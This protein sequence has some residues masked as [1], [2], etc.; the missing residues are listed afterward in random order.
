[1]QMS[2]G[3]DDQD[4]VHGGFLPPQAPP[5]VA[6]PGSS[7]GYYGGPLTTGMPAP[8]PPQQGFATPPVAPTQA[9]PA[10]GTPPPAWQPWMALAALAIAFIG[11]GVLGALLFVVAAGGEVDVE[12]ASAPV[13][14]GSLVL[15]DFAFVGAAIG[16]AA[17]GSR[18]LPWH[19]GW[20]PVR[21]F[22]PA[23]GW[24]VLLYVAF[25]AFTA[26]FLLATGQEE[27]QD[28][29]AQDLGADSSTAAAIAV[30]VLVAVGAPIV[31]ELLFRGF[32]FGSLRQSLPLWP[33][34]LITGV[35]FGFAHVFGSPI[36]FILP[37]AFLG[38]GL[39][40]LYHQTG[41]LYP[42]MAVH[43]INNSVAGVSALDW[44]PVLIPVV[45]A[46]SLASIALVAWI[47]RALTG[48]V[49]ADAP[50]P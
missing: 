26:V 7:G 27:Q 13:M 8:A 17:I 3:Q 28:T 20:R 47:V 23:V 49:P 39:C 32:V 22:W 21:A 36:A 40:L 25:I 31:E 44:D 15:Q 50:A 35:L 9:L 41:S 43:A 1:M 16:V 38:T 37:L 6:P 19:F 18:P 24:T 42:P 30:C 5:S 45:I 2:G 4:E 29:L 14:L 10:A 46:G 34:A 48:P 11:G 12:N 33:A